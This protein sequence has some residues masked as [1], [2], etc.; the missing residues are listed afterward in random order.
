[1]APSERPRSHKLGR[2]LIRHSLFPLLETDHE[3]LQLLDAPRLQFPRE[4][5][6]VEVRA[7]NVFQFVI[8]FEEEGQVLIRDVDVRVSA[9]FTLLFRAGLP[10]GEG[11]LVDF[12]L[13]VRGVVLSAFNDARGKSSTHGRDGHG[14][15]SIVHVDRAR[16]DASTHLASRSTE[17]GKEL[18]MDERRFL[19]PEPP[20]DVSGNAKVWVL[21]DR[22]RN[23]GR[24]FLDFI[25][26]LSE[27]VGEGRG[28]RSASLDGCEM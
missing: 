2:N 26:V 18:G 14:V 22:T 6:A 24:D 4:K 11:V 25:E 15:R 28:E 27:Y 7:A 21:V 3:F 5:A 10:A 12:L 8:V 20:G 1:M 19:V 13:T 16:V 9:V 23:Q 17:R